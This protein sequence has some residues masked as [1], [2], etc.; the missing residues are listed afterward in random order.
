MNNYKKIL[1]LLPMLPMLMANAPAPK[2]HPNTNYTDFEMSIVKEEVN[3]EDS[4]LYDYT[5]SFKNTGIGYIS[6]FYATSEECSNFGYYFGGLG[7]SQFSYNGV[8]IPNQEQES[9]R[10]KV[11]KVNNYSS[12]KCTAEAYTDFAD[13]VTVSGD[14][15]L[16]KSNSGKNG[17]TVKAELSGGD[18]AKY[19]YGLILKL[20][21][22]SNDFYIEVDEFEDFRFDNVDEF[23]VSKVSKVEVVEVTRSV[24]YGYKENNGGNAYAAVLL[25]TFVVPFVIILG[26]ICAIIIVAIICVVCVS[27]KRR[28][29]QS[30]VANQENDSLNNDK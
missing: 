20:T 3:A 17:Y 1:I 22:D 28:K 5:F 27:A 30:A 23:D 25:G 19:N 24:A 29:K 16:N 12:I 8:F 15:S 7:F 18:R 6:S 11:E 9:I 10:T 4:T 13:D 26:A 14:L 2:P 21:Y